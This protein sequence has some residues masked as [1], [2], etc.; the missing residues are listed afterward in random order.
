MRGYK[1]VKVGT[2]SWSVRAPG[3]TSMAICWSEHVAELLASVLN[4]IP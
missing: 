1:V 4:R 3:G 2:D